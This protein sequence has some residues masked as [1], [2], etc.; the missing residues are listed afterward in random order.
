MRF[1]L[2][3]LF[4]LTAIGPAFADEASYLAKKRSYGEAIAAALAEGKSTDTLQEEALVDLEGQL[5]AI[6]G[7][8]DIDGLPASGSLNPSL[9]YKDEVGST[10]LDGLDL[11]SADG[12]LRAVASTRRLLEAWLKAKPEWWKDEPEIARS[13]EAAFRS[14]LFYTLAI[15]SD[16]GISRYADIPIAKPEG[17]EIAAAMLIVRAQEAGPFAPEEIVVGVVAGG[18]VRIATLMHEAVFAATEACKSKWAEHENKAETAFKAYQ[19]SGLEDQAAFDTYSGHIASADA[20]FRACFK[21]KAVSEPAFAKVTDQA[22]A[23]V[24]RLAGK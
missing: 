21:E 16:A 19:A 12:K 15:S 11:E 2:P 17:V 23:L 18:K 7:P 1:L 10:H 9:L 6:V 8:L 13:L 20:A 24:R 14:D 3:V 4:A 5:A 22:R